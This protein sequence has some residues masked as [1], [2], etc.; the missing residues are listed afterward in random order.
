MRIAFDLDGVFADMQSA[1]EREAR[2]LFR[3]PD[4]AVVTPARAPVD[5][6]DGRESTTPDTSPAESGSVEEIESDPAV[7]RLHLTAAQ[8]RRLWR[9]V[10]AIP[11][12]W[13]T[14]EE[15]EAGAVG[16]LAQLADERKWEVLFITNRPETAGATAQ[17]QSQRW[18][19]RRGFPLPSV[20]V[21]RG[22]RGHLAAALHLDVVVDDRP[23][24]CLDVMAESPARAILVWRADDGLPETAVRL[25]IGRVKSVS[26]CLRLLEQADQPASPAAEFLERLRGLLGLQR[27]TGTR[28]PWPELQ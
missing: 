16:Q 18:L 23:Q 13:T 5:D 26:E 2:R 9:A 3:A 19:E 20:Y 17:R 1:F 15:I 12:F 21:M 22:S 28:R 25:G 6:G 14:L 10:R 11:D 7:E 24:N 4:R 27:V 8:H